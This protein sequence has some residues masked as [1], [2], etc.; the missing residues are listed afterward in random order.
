MFKYKI[1]SLLFLLT[2]FNSNLYSVKVT[3]LPFLSKDKE[4]VEKYMVD[5]GMPRAFEISLRNTHMFD[6][7][8]YDLLISYFES[9]DNVMDYKALSTN[10]T[11]AS[12]FVKDTFESDYLI[13]GEVLDFNLKQGG[14][15]TAN[16]EF[17]VN[18]IDINTAKTVKTFTNS[19]SYVLPGNSVVYNSEDALFYE[20]ALGWATILAFNNIANEISEFLE[21]PPLIGTVTRIEDNKIFINL[22][23]RNNIKIGDEF[24]IYSVE[25]YLDLP[26]NNEY[27]INKIN[28]RKQSS[29]TNGILTNNIDPNNF[30]VHNNTNSY[31]AT[32]QASNNNNNNNNNKSNISK[33]YNNSNNASSSVYRQTRENANGD[34]WYTSEMLYIY[35]YYKTRK[36]LVAKAKVIEL[37]DNY[38]ILENKSNAKIE[39]L[40]EV[41]INEEK[42]KNL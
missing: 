40:M 24:G 32:N 41:K 25:K 11:I 19:A 30:V 13:T 42:D 20:S 10:I 21:I 28:E 12:D 17:K 2:L 15:D 38:A 26:P 33:Q 4:W 14:K 6:V 7:S 3:V 37:Y 29:L 5:D 18:L 8:D 36:T 35:R 1:I 31:T 23:K 16:V 39:L 34:F 22:G 27:L 9:Y